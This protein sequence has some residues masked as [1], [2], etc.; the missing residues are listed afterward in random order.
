[1]ENFTYEELN[2][3]A[4][5]DSGTRKKTITALQDMREY[6]E[7]DEKELMELTDSAI[8]KLKTLSDASFD[9]LELFPD[10]EE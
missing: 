8:R 5:Y 3:I 2:L 6:L 4:I 7:A 1:M 9:E 10:I